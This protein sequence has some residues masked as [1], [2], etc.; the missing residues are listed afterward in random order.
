M[1][2][3][4][5]LYI[6]NRRYSSWSLRP[7]ILMRTQDI[8]FECEVIPFEQTMGTA[9]YG[10]TARIREVSP[11]GQ[12]PVLHHGDLVIPGSLAII[13]YLAEL[14][15]QKPIWPDDLRE[16]AR[17]RAIAL[18]M[19]AGFGPLRSACGMNFGRPVAG[20]DLSEAVLADVRRIEEIFTDALERCDG[21]FL[22]GKSFGAADAMY[23]PVINRLHVYDLPRGEV[24]QAW[25]DAV[26]GLP[27]W[28]QWHKAALKEPWRIA[29]YEDL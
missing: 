22:F 20:K 8:P 17:A 27:A 7:W 18:E 4:L 19:L 29:A 6:G 14:Y 28:R 23:A 10:G 9:A 1:A 24:T 5:K 15:P 13:E 25:M 21:P 12:V 16:R 11:T 26:M 2:Q 3:D